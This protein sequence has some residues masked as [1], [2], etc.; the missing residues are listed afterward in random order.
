MTASPKS[1]WPAVKYAQT[2]RGS[3]TNGQG[4][5]FPGGLDLT[6]PALRLPPGA[7]RDCLNFEVAEFGGYRRVDGYE[8]VDGRAAPSAASYTIIQCGG[9]QDFNPDFNP[10]FGQL[11]FTNVPV[12]GQVVTQAV[13]GATGKIIAVVTGP[14]PYIAVTQVTGVFDGMNPLTTPGPAIVGSAS[15]TPVPIGARTRA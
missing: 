5:P 13:T 14:L 7:L 4:Q 9:I 10:D 3:G 15:P 1:A 12:V 6:T 8:R 11:A 2:S